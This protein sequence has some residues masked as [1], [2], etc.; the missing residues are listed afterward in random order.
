M[1]PQRDPPICQRGNECAQQR[2]GR[3]PGAASPEALWELLLGGR[4]GVAEAPPDRSWM[5]ELYSPVPRTPGRVPTKR[6]GFIDA[7]DQFDPAFFGMTPREAHR[8]DPRLRLLLECA[9]EA[10]QD[11]GMPLAELARLRTG[12]YIGN[13]YNDYW[14]R[15]VGEMD[16]LDFYSELGSA[17]S[18]LSG[19]LA[20]AFDL[21]GPAITVDT[22]CSSSL[23]A[24]HFACQALRPGECD[25]AL[26]G[27]TNLV[28]TPYNTITFGWAGALNADH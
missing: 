7:I 12:C 4:E 22:A 20:Y 3:F 17:R 9:F 1:T 23:V 24:I 18:S 25:L 27:G 13:M 11:G 28:L 15:Q 2:R 16:S 26:T 6:G 10:A 5:H 8:A 21:R 14:L 19:R